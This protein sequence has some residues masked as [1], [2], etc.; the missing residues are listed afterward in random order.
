MFDESS[1]QTALERVESRESDG[2]V[3]A[4]FSHMGPSLAD[5]LA[6]IE[7]IQAAGGRFASVADGID[8][9]TPTGRLL[10]RLLLSVVH[11]HQ[12]QS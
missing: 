12:E 11:Q 3:V 2:L 7:R 8:L 9:D 5:A 4:R 10:L 6:T 1:L